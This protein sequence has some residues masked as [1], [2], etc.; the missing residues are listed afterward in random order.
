MTINLE[1]FLAH[2][3]NKQPI[4]KD[5]EYFS[6]MSSLCNEAMK[7]TFELNTSYHEPEEVR[8]LFSK[9]IG[10]PVDDGFSLFPPFSADFG[11]NITLGKGVFINA[12]C[13]FQ[14][15]GGITLEDGALVGHNVVMATLNHDFSINNRGMLHPAPIHIKKNVWIG[16][17]S[18]I[19]SGVTIGENAIVAAGAVVTKDIPANAIAGGVPAK[20]I[21]F[22]T[23][24]ELK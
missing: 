9:L 17:N 1:D 11:K 7:I 21:R 5:S 3:K 22:L 4:L 10:H 18:T 19:T 20:I 6:F 8:Q 13:R 23:P 24:E 15:Q 16:S 2:V 12:G 14:D